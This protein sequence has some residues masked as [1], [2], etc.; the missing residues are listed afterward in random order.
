MSG[1]WT[2]ASLMLDVFGVVT[3]AGWV[4]PWQWFALGGFLC[5]CIFIIWRDVEQHQIIQDR[6]SVKVSPVDERRSFFYLEVENVGGAATFEAQVEIVKGKEF[7]SLLPD[8]YSPYWDETKHKKT[9]IMKGHKN[10]LLVASLHM[11]GSAPMPMNFRF[12]YWESAYFEGMLFEGIRSIDST[13]WIPGGKGLVIPKFI[14]RVTISS[15]PS[16]REELF[17]KY[18]EL[19]T[20]GLIWLVAK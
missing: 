6:P 17:D 16:L 1:M 12:H 4:V 9:Q 14:L 7:V 11:S 10:R 5:F 15:D 13:S 20:A 19:S 2:A 3:I 18:Y 8:R